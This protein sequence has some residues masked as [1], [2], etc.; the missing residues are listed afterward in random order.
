M[1]D[2]K[3]KFIQRPAPV[4]VE[5]RPIYKIGQ[6]LLILY[7]S[8]RSYKSSLNRLQLFNWAFKEKNR[9][10]KIIESSVKGKLDIYAWGFDPALTVGLRF[11]IAEKL[12][13]EDVTTFR[14]TAQGIKFCESILEDENIFLLEKYFLNE[15]KKNITEKMVDS[16]AKNWRTQ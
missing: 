14:L 5:H 10:K 7:L 16:V 8:S 13:V 12:I 9:Q 3:I 2:V 6:I 4:F 11:A 15:V 1:T